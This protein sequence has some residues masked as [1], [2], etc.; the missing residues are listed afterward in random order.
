MTTSSGAA[1]RHV[2]DG[3]PAAALARLQEEVRARPADAKL[4]VFLFQLLCVL[5]QWE[6]ALTQLKVASEMEPL[7]L[8]MAQIYGDA[9]RCEAVRD[10]VFH[11]RKSPM[12]LGEPDQWLA[13]LIESRLRSGRGETA[14]AEDLRLR[15]FADAPGSSGDINGTPF[16]WIADADSRLGPV[17]EAIINGRYYWVPFSR[18]L[19]V[20]LEAPEDLRD[21]VWMPAQMQFENGGESLALLPTRY[22]GSQ[23]SPDG[24]IALARKTEWQEFAPDAFAGLG[25]RLFATN[26]GETPMLDVRSLT[27]RH[28]IQAS[29][30]AADGDHA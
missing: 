8:P 12:I 29:E 26:G 7:A 14:Q 2:K 25:Q 27:L 21:L 17:L 6:R 16:E 11:G 9:V 4:R 5:G 10:E 18:V 28:D 22:P 30:V 3:D 13:L 19:K 15:A 24:G 1:E 23:A 20:T